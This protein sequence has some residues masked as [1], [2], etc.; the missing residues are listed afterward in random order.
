MKTLVRS[1]LTAASV[2]VTVAPAYAQVSSPIL[3][4]QRSMRSDADIVRIQE[5]AVSIEHLATELP[6]ALSQGG[7]SIGVA[8]QLGAQS[9]FAAG[10]R[11]RAGALGA[12]VRAIFDERATPQASAAEAAPSMEAIAQNYGQGNLNS[13]FHYN[14]YLLEPSPVRYRP[15]RSAGRMFFTF[16]GTSWFTC[17]AALISST[18]LVTAGHCV[19]QGGNGAEGWIQEAYFVPSYDQRNGATPPFGRCNILRTATTTGWFNEG[20]IQQGYDVA[21]ALCGRSYN[22]SYPR[23]QNEFPGSKLGYFGFCYEN[24]RW[25]Y[26]FLTQIGYPGNYYDGEYMTIGQHI[27]TTTGGNNDYIFGSGMRGGSSGGP[28]V[29][30]IGS[31][32]D[33]SSDLGQLTT[34]NVI[35]A[36]TSWGYISEQ[37]KIQGASPLSG[38]DNANNFRGLYNQ[39]CRASRELVGRYSCR[40]LTAS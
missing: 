9:D 18:I 6:V 31:I 14:D 23:Y 29:S 40:F 10:P 36:V 21:T 35:Y 34:R 15:Y 8:P 27:E 19:H 24:C 13:I 28:H 7:G 4:A 17:T 33:S 12:P 30:N 22:A 11:I 26:Q 1:L 16:D 5:T 37:W 3:G 25:D 39:M 2:M 38:V 32:Q 20:N